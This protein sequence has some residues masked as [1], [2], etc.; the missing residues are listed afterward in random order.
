M[1]Y[2]ESDKAWGDAERVL[3]FYIQRTWR[4]AGLKWID[5]NEQEVRDVFSCLRKGVQADIRAAK[6]AGDV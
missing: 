1:T 3:T 6:E 5:E 4:A 2:S